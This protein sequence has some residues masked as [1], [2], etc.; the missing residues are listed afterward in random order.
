MNKYHVIISGCGPVGATLANL[1]GSQGLDVLVLEKFTKVYDKPR[2]IVLDW[3]AMRTFQFCGIAEE[4][5][6]TTCPHPGTDFIGLKNQLIK[7]FDPL[8]PPYALGWPST[9]MFVQPELERLLRD[10]IHLNPKIDL[11]LGTEVVSF[12][13]FPDE[14]VANFII[15]KTGEKLSARAN[16]L[17]GCDGAN[18]LIRASLGIEMEDY[19]FDEWWLVVD[20]WQNKKTNLPKKT[21][22][23][24]HPTRPA[25]YVVGPNNLRRWEI[26]I[27]PG[28]D[29]KDFSSKDKVLETL[30]QFVDLGALDIWRSAAY[31]FNAR[32]SKKWSKDR[33]FLAGDAC[34][35]TPPF[36]GQGL[37]VGI[38]D[39]LNISWKINYSIRHGHNS[40]LLDSYEVE[41]RPHASKVI[42]HAKEFGLIIGELDKNR[43]ELRDKVLSDL[44]INGE[45]ETKRQNFIPD[46]EGGIIDGYCKDELGT[47]LSGKL[48]IQPTLIV[49]NSPPKLLDDLIPMEFVIICNGAEP[50]TWANKHK[51]YWDKIKGKIVVISDRKEIEKL[52]GRYFAFEESGDLYSNWMEKNLIKAVLVRP[53]RY[54][55]GGA[56]SQDELSYLIKKLRTLIQT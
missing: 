56:N 39:A 46:L 43:A 12:K 27:M 54:I 11:R 6:K 31:R 22:Q 21:T 30:S 50:L 45:V 33:V 26:K 13:S 49:K 20:A 1:L 8:P 23:Y 42:E 34:H 41:R 55:F 32:V 5:S 25:T 29:P 15:S 48:M 37:C 38:R 2:A 36:L 3:E 19:N 28:E 10:R 9:L 51:N 18:S 24:C 7:L 4:L 35:Q 52:I 44:L 40:K 17:I 16:Y 53:D 14:V 47:N